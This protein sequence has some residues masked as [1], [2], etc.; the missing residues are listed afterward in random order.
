MPL[1]DNLLS[2]GSEG[3]FLSAK[4]RSFGI[5]FSHLKT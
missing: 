3:A 1:G 4:K 5:S 2:C